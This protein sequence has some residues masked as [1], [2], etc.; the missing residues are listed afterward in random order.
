MR[1]F[2]GRFNFK[3]Q[4]QVS[5]KTG[6]VDFLTT[7]ASKLPEERKGGALRYDLNRM[8]INFFISD[9]KSYELSSKS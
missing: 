6:N 4:F 2:F 1:M 5:P 8:L 3:I 9:F 7:K